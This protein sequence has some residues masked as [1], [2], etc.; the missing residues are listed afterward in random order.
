MGMI[1][2]CT[3]IQMMITDNLQ[4]GE[5]QKVTAE[6]A[7]FNRQDEALK[8][9][10]KNLA[11]LWIW[12]RGCYFSIKSHQIHLDIRNVRNNI[13]NVLPGLYVQRPFKRSNCISHFICKSRSW[14]LEER[15][16]RDRI[17]S[18]WSPVC[19]CCLWWFGA[20]NHVSDILSYQKLM[21][22]YTRR[23]N[24]MRTWFLVG[25]SFS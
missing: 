4:E 16:D 15:E 9:L 24:F 8:G 12:E 1:A 25:D 23:E 22:L 2:G 6:K 17:Q 20:P 3:V 21:Q 14:S 18:V 5:P 19:F 11:E 7:N 10:S 13:K